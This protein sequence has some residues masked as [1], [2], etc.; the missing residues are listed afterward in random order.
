MPISVFKKPPDNKEPKEKQKEVEAMS[1]QQT[2]DAQQI[3]QEIQRQRQKLE[4]R[5]DRLE[6]RAEDLNERED[7]L[8]E[9]ENQIEELRQKYIQ[10]LESTSSLTQEEAKQQLLKELEQKLTGEMAAKIKEAEKQARSE[11]KK[12]AKKIIVEA[13]QR[14]A[15]DYIGETTTSIINLPNEDMKG[16]IIGREGRNVKALEKATG[17]DYEIDETPE[18]IRISSLDPVRREVAKIATE[19]LIADGR[20]HPAHIEETVERAKKEIEEEAL[21]TG[22]DVAYKVG[23]PDLQPNILKLIGKLKYRTSYGQNQL[24]HTLEVVNLAK[25]L[26]E[27][28][29]AN[30]KLTTVAALLH[31]IGKVKTVEEGQGSHTEIG[32]RLLKKANFDEDI[33]HAAM[34][35]HKDEEFKSVEAALVYVADAISGARPGA[36]REDYEAYINRINNLEE[37]AKSFEGV[38]EAYALSAGREVRVIVKPEKINDDEAVILSHKI[39]NK[40]EQEATYPGTVKVNV[41]REVRAEEVA[42]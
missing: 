37:I 10:K 6:A 19:K 23:V 3:Q 17:V 33:I 14:G 13:I 26:A 30:V 20:I 18:E 36:R 42:K 39:A 35:H 12:R 2:A 1:E 7:K 21:E 28:V 9:K 15:T 11:A 8:R 32:R 16:R 29:G 4:E 40:I 31:D 41:I 38:S 25:A 27:E 34:A 22:R 5:F 24:E